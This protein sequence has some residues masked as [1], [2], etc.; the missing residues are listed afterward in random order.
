MSNLQDASLYER[1]YAVIRQIPVGQVGTYGQVASIVGGKCGPRT[2]GYALSNLPFGADVP[3]QRVIN[4]QGK[5]SPRTSALGSGQQREML[6][7]EGII[8]NP[9]THKT[10]FKQF[11]WLGPDWDWLED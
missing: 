8:F 3:W 9:K 7:A 4:R 11:G 6:E 5:V 10:D 1:I 2:V